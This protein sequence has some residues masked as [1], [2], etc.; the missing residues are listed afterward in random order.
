MAGLK[1]RVLYSAG[2]QV[3]SSV[4]N[5][6]IL[7]A[8]AG[9]SSV[10]AFGLAI[11]VF[12]I[13]TAALGFVRGAVGTPLLLMSAYTGKRIRA[14]SAHAVTAAAAFG[15][16]IGVVA[17]G[18]ALALHEPAVGIAYAVAAPVVLAQDA[19]RFTAMSIGEPEHA[20]FSDGLWTLVAFGVL[21]V[22]WIRPDALSI[23]QM[24]W[25]W[26]AAGTLA[27]GYL[28]VR[29]R[30]LPRLRGLYRWW[31]S[32]WTH[33]IRFGFESG[34]DQLAAI[35]IVAISTVFIG[36]VAAASLRGAVTVLGPFAVLISSLPLIVI[37]ESVRAGHTPKQVWSTLRY[38]AWLTSAM[39]AT[40]GFAA[41][42]LPEVLGR[43]ILGESWAEARHVLPFLGLEYAAVCWIAGVY[44]LYR[45]QGASGRL[46]KM[47][48][49][50]SL[51]AIM[52]CSSAAF[53]MKTAVG[54]AIGLA[55]SSI[56]VA[57]CLVVAAQRTVRRTGSVPSRSPNKHRSS[58]DHTQADDR[59]RTGTGTLAGTTT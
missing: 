27:L 26:T 2:D 36:T 37:P 30:V 15:V 50:Q 29:I 24:I 4:S 51:T 31:T 23:T 10:S 34:I 3:L 25:L 48:I 33:R 46:L 58:G 54:V 6:L 14:E 35:V 18:V 21:V 20:F 55:L 52:I 41:P 32:F 53:L 22:T 59:R 57:L 43:L 11:L 8:M 42:F 17:F 7:F 38:A 39:A 49:I 19:L 9:P 44:N 45:T 12:S 13:L 47:R 28:M 56:L 16:L 1:L 5:A 40:I